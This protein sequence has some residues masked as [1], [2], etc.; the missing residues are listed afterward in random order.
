[1]DTLYWLNKD[2]INNNSGNYPDY[3]TDIFTP[4]LVSN[5]T[6]RSYAP[7]SIGFFARVADEAGLSANV[8]YENT[9]LSKR[10]VPRIVDRSM[11]SACRYT[12]I[13]PSKLIDVETYRLWAIGDVGE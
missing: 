13:T 4:G 10:Y 3:V 12:T 6:G 1:M 7:L 2:F 5:G 11:G 8:T 9:N